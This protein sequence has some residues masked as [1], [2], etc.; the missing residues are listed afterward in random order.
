MAD[1]MRRTGKDTPLDALVSLLDT[2]RSLKHVLRRVDHTWNNLH[3][4]AELDRKLPQ[5]LNS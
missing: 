4:E 5:R 1:Y 2:P 3:G